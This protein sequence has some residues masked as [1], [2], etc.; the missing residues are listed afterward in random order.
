ML[1]WCSG[2][3]NLQELLGQVSGAAGCLSLGQGTHLGGKSVHEQPDLGVEPSPL[4][5]WTSDGSMMEELLKTF[6]YARLIK[7]AGFPKHIIF[8]G[9]NCSSI[10]FLLDRIV[11]NCLPPC[12]PYG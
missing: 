6:T 8:A 12:K 2:E 10:L 9:Q 7:L 3:G 5:R 4:M 11:Q 1:C